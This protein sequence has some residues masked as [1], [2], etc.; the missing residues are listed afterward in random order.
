MSAVSVSAVGAPGV[1]GTCEDATEKAA[2]L[3]LEFVATI[4]NTMYFIDWAAVIVKVEPVS[5]AITE[6]VPE[7]VAASVAEPQAYHDVVIAIDGSPVTVAEAV[8]PV[9]V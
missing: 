7:S 9:R 1:P 2:L 3:P 8:L 5:P 4:R 6:H